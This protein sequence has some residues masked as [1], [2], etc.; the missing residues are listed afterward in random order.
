MKGAQRQLMLARRKRAKAGLASGKFPPGKTL[1][2]DEKVTSRNT[3]RSR[4]ITKTKSGWEGYMERRATATKGSKK[5]PMSPGKY[6]SGSRSRAGT[7][8]AKPAAK[9]TAK[10]AAKPRNK[11]VPIPGSFGGPSGAQRGQRGGA[12]GSGGSKPTAKPRNKYVPVPG[13]FGGPS[14]A[15]RGQRGGATGSGGGK[16][17]AK[18]KPTRRKINWRLRGAFGGPSARQRNK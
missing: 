6:Y 4:N 2:A 14:G 16:P 13:S 12:T 15:Q 3:A 5:D 7:S 8:K 9:P 1:P 17:T 11:Y 18:P 10:P